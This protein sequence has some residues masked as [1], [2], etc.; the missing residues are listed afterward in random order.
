MD[1]DVVRLATR[2]GLCDALDA[3]FLRILE[4]NIARERAAVRTP[5]LGRARLADLTETTDTH[6]DRTVRIDLK[7]GLER[8]RGDSGPPGNF[9]V[10]RVHIRT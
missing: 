1:V 7:P 10:R 4:M 9:S 5:L 8:S 3:Q 6:T 2:I